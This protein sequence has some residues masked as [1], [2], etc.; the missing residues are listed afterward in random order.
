MSFLTN[1]YTVFMQ[2]LTLA[3]MIAVGFTADKC[4]FFTEKTAKLCNNLLFYVI[5]PCVIVNSFLNVDYTPENANGFFIS[6]ACSASLHVVGM[7]LVR[8]L[9]NKG[10]KKRTSVF[11]YATMYANMGYMG[12]PLSRAV[13][14]AVSGGG[15][16]GVFY[17]SAAI[18]CFNIF[19]FT[20]GVYTM[21]GDGNKFDLKKIIINPGALSVLVGMP[22]FL[23]D[24]QLPSVITTPISSI[25]SM[26]TPLAMMMLGT[27]LANANVKSAFK[28]KNMYL[29]AF[30]KLLVLPLILIALFSLCGVKGDILIVASVFVS[31]P[32][33][34]NTAMFAAKFDKDTALASQICGFST[35]LSIITMPVCVALGVMLS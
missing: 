7:I 6:F 29:V 21:S 10:D 13:V 30:L 35:I 32:T 15:D 8:F 20:H 24:V 16:M 4:G 27:Y 22:L 2:V 17:C 25:G 1:M 31:A 5:N 11:K 3:V 18:T 26:N 12:L 23:L 33:A 9:F 34:T 14:D 28:E 19:A